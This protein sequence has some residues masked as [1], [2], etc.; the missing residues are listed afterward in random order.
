MK[1]L[2]YKSLGRFF[3]CRLKFSEYIPSY[4]FGRRGFPGKK[5]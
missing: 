2:I 1:R 3:G 4:G 5:I